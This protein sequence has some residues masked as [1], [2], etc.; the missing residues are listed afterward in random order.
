MQRPIAFFLIISL[1]CS[2]IN[3]MMHEHILPKS[4]KSGEKPNYFDQNPIN[5]YRT[6]SQSP[7]PVFDQYEP[8][9]P[10]PN[11]LFYYQQASA[12]EY[13]EITPQP[14]RTNIYESQEFRP[15]RTTA[16]NI[17]QQPFEQTDEQD[18]TLEENPVEEQECTPKAKAA[19][20][21]FSILGGIGGVIFLI[22][23]IFAISSNN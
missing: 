4:K 21:F 3:S 20:A 12:P 16:R 10:S 14:S 22:A 15:H 5:Y 2:N 13:S 1:V 7:S 17:I 19:C 11:P 18:E 9:S 8:K 6:K 23:T